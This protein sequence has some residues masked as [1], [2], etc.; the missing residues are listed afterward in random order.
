MAIRPAHLLLKYRY[1]KP[2]VCNFK[3][4]SA[5]SGKYKHNGYQFEVQRIKIHNDSQCKSG[6]LVSADQNQVNK[7]MWQFKVDIFLI[8]TIYLFPFCRPPQ[9]QV[10][11]RKCQ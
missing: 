7:K 2:L 9:N 3:T 4:V 8:V 6:G 10:K 1:F 5:F 11:N